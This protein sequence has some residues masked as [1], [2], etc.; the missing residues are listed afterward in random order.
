MNLLTYLKANRIITLKQ[1][2]R[3][4]KQCWIDKRFPK[5]IECDLGCGLNSS[6]RVI[7]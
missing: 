5:F 4:C 7:K 2:L 6:I 1:H 3:Y